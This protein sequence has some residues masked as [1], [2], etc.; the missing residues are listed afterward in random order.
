MVDILKKTYPITAS[1]TDNHRFCKMSSLLGYLQ[2]MA[3]DHAIIMQ[4]DS[5]RLIEKY[6]AAWIVARIYVKLNRPI[7]FKDELEIHT[8]HRGAVKSAVVFRD[9]D[10][11]VN[12]THVGEAVV[13]WILVDLQNKKIL[14]P[15][16]YPEIVDSPV[17]E[18]IKDIVPAKVKMPESLTQEMVRKL[19]YSDIDVNGHV[20]NA[21]YV[22]IACDAIQ[23]DKY[24]NQFISELEINYLA[25][26]F[27]DEE[28][29]LMRGEQDGI[30]YVRGADHDSKNRFEVSLKLDSM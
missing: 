5:D 10:L 23:Y 28:I 22:D 20:N 24:T 9:F 26:C 29:I 14:K 4:V 16:S 13:S 2:N 3:T 18:K 19:Y 30:Q 15:L 1:D 12:D 21:K 11:F 17:P 7:M 25:E 8:W 27:P 6:G